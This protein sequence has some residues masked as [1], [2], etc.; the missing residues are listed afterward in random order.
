LWVSSSSFPVGFLKDNDIVVTVFDIDWKVVS[1][2]YIVKK[3]KKR[4]TDLHVFLI[5]PGN[6][7]P[8]AIF[9]PRQKRHASGG[10]FSGKFL[11]GKELRPIDGDFGE[12]KRNSVGVGVIRLDGTCNVLDELAYDWLLCFE[13]LEWLRS[14]N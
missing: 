14:D 2:S 9:L 7:G 10:F 5:L 3:E 4:I 8:H 6:G 13:E 12:L 1:V 11:E